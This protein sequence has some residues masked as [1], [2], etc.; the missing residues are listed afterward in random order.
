[1]TKPTVGR[2][3]H[4]YDPK[5]VQKIGW[6]D[7]YGGR[8]AGPYAAIVTNDVGSGLSLLILFPQAGPLAQ[9]AVPEKPEVDS[10]KAYWTWPTSIEKARA[11]REV[12]K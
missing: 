8:G 11:A 1:M 7:G 3:V 6:P 9:D 12:E 5:I 2:I 4:Y 10:E